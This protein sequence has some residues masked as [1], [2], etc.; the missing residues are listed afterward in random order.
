MTDHD[1]TSHTPLGKASEAVGQYTPTLLCPL[2]RNLT[3]SDLGIEAD[4][5]PFSGTD[6]WNLYELS[7]LNR[8]G[9]PQAAVGQLQIPCDSPNLVESKSL[10][11]Y[12]NS[13]NQSRFGSI[14]GVVKTLE[15]DLSACVQAPITVSLQPLNHAGRLFA[16]GKINGHCLDAQD[17]SVNFYKPEPSLLS[18]SGGVEVT[19]CLY[20]DLFRS[21]CPV[22]GQPDWATVVIDYH[23][24]AIDRENLLKYLVSFRQHSG[25]HEQCVERIFVDISSHCQPASLSVY[26]AFLRRGGIDINPLRSNAKSAAE[27]STYARLIRQ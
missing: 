21:C 17:L 18:A 10:K 20:S 26:A 4:A 13:F 15:A 12:L 25:F 11:L 3:R 22:T 6:T 7:W 19:E 27:L 23:G 24:A 2:P 5:L 1:Y 14:E 9:M 8:R 16:V